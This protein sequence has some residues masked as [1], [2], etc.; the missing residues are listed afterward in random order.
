MRL[1]NNE[2]N[3]TR[4]IKITFADT[5]KRYEILRN[6]KDLKM[7]CNTGKECELDFCDDEDEHVHIYINTDKT[8]QQLKEEKELREELKK[9]KQTEQNLIIRNGKI[10][11]KSSH[12]RWVEL[13]ED[14]Y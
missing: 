10:I 8:K 12:V 4:P 14:G 3:K 11:K 13:A 1:G 7:Y 5:Q 9:R 6:N 2:D